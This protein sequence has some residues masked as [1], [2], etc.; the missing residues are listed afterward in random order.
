[1]P[2]L[3]CRG[4]LSHRPA[5][6]QKVKPSASVQFSSSGWEN[7]YSDS[8]CMNDDDMENG[9]HSDSSSRSQLGRF[10]ATGNF[11]KEYIL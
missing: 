7:T 2:S 8:N 9:I 4:S 11:S 6:A 1:M 3:P 10:M 5:L